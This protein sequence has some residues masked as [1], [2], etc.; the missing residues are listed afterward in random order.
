MR[1]GIPL[2]LCMNDTESD[3]NS[4]NP[5][6]ILLLTAM[7][8]ALVMLLIAFTF[9]IFARG[10]RRAGSG[11]QTLVGRYPAWNPPEG[12]SFSNQT[13]RIGDVWYRNCARITISS[14]GLYIAVSIPFPG[15]PGGIALIPWNIITIEGEEPSFWKTFTRIRITEYEHL[16][17]TLPEEIIRLFPIP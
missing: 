14:S 16:S 10:F 2:L 11:L 3:M 7:I 12:E 17:L 4:M 13:V 15:I 8:I 5:D 6:A 1:T 9:Y